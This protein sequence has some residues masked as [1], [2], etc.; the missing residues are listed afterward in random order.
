MSSKLNWLRVSFSVALTS[1]FIEKT[2]ALLVAS[3]KA[4][5]CTAAY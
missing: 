2:K 4:K 5:S 1:S 3:A